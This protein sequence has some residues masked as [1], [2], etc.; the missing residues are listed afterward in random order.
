MGL[1]DIIYNIEDKADGQYES[2]EDFIHSI[3]KYGYSDICNDKISPVGQIVIS[4]YKDLY[5]NKNKHLAKAIAEAI[6]PIVGSGDEKQWIKEV[7]KEYQGIL[8]KSFWTLP[9]LSE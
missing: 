1:I 6:W 5:G 2:Q 7:T 9:I 4:Y 3:N 8:K